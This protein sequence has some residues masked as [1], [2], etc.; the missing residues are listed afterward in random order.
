MSPYEDETNAMQGQAGRRTPRVAAIMFGVVIHLVTG[1]LL[2]TMPP[3][4]IG[5]LLLYIAL[6]VVGVLHILAGAVLMRE[7]PETAAITAVF[8]SDDIPWHAKRC[9]RCDG[10]IADVL[11]RG[12][13][14]CPSCAA[15]FST[16]DV[17]W[18]SADPAGEPAS[19]CPHEQRMSGPHLVTV[20]AVM[21]LAFVAI[22]VIVGLIS[23]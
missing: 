16:R 23:P 14:R 13:R 6:G 9:P 10:D 11:M 4:S 21:A 19:L 2:F 18:R 17:G 12:G 1:T 22:A 7:R 3:G 8:E 5:T 15:H 20:L